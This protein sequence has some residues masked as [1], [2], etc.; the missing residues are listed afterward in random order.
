MTSTDGAAL[1]SDDQVSQA[2]VTRARQS[3]GN[4]LTK[5]TN[6]QYTL[7]DPVGGEGEGAGKL[8]FHFL[9]TPV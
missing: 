3:Y 1:G 2:Y 5:H 7:A 4:T 9:Q 8:G 6:T